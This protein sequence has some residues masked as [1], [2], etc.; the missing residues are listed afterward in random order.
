LWTL[1]SADTAATLIAMPDWLPAPVQRYAFEATARI[2]D[3]NDLESLRRF[4]CDDRMIYV[5][6]ELQRRAASEAMAQSGTGALI[7]YFYLAWIWAHYLK[8]S[9]RTEAG[10][11]ALALELTK[12]AATLHYARERALRDKN[13]QLARTIRTA[14][15]YCLELA[16]RE[17]RPNLLLTVKQY[18]R[19]D[20]ARAYVRLLSYLTRRV[21]GGPLLHT[22][23][24]TASVALGRPIT[25][26]QVRDWTKSLPNP[27]M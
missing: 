14:A 26:Q 4:A 24:R 23:A 7:I 1:R 22:T 21:F 6:R 25:P 8:F 9:I 16:D 27:P 20:E 2:I 19:D 10:C 17:R 5:W 18:G 11:A 13:P 3:P 12:T 15:K